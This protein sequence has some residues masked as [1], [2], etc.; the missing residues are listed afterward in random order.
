MKHVVLYSLLI[1]LGAVFWAG[2][3]APAPQYI[4]EDC[5]LYTDLKA[6]KVNPAGAMGRHL[7]VEVVFKVCPPEEGL[8]AIQRKRIELKHELIALLSAK[9]MEDLE[10]PLRIEKLRREILFLVNDKLLKKS[11]AVDVSITAFELL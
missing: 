6:I 9:T 7:R 8:A 3:C 10:D 4:E 5:P 11:R 1:C 2:S